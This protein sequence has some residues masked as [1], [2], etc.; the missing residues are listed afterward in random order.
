MRLLPQWKLLET[1]KVVQGQESLLRAKFPGKQQDALLKR[2]LEEE[3]GSVSYI[4]IIQRCIFNATILWE[5]PELP[6]Q[7]MTEL[8]VGVRHW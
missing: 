3:N 1:F 5:S 6:K 8:R 2:A 7:E 4:W